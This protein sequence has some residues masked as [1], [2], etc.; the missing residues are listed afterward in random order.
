MDSD[1]S[2]QRSGR[3]LIVLVCF[4]IAALEGYDI[5]AFGIAAPKL[6]AQ[7][8]LSPGQ[9]GWAASAA[10]FGLVAGAFGGGWLADRIGRR[11]VLLAAVITFGLFS[12]ATG[13]SADYATLL[14]ARLATG[15]GFGGAMPNLI[16]IATEISAPKRRA[17]TVTM[18]FCGLPAGGAAVALLAR[19][20][21]QGLDWRTTFFLGGRTAASVAG[22]RSATARR[23]R[24]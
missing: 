7:F 10:M 8:A 21:R 9:T 17:A 15:I 16:A 3:G 12:I 11:P 6:A 2:M 19:T 18:M 4:L 20:V 1:A 13:L 14:L 5:Q 23:Q 22:G 24:S